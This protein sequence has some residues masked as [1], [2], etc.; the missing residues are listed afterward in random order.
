M[1]ITSGLPTMNVLQNFFSP[2]RQ[3][4]SIVFSRDVSLCRD[5][6][7]LRIVLADPSV[8]AGAPRPPSREQIKKQK[9]AQELALMQKQLAELLD[10]GSATRHTM[11]HLVFVEQALE[12]KGLR[13]LHKLPLE[14]LERA[15]DQF[16]GLVTNWSPAGLA[17]LRSKMAVAIIDREHMDPDAEAD[18]Y[19]TSAVVESAPQPTARPQVDAGS[20]TTEITDA[21]ALAAA[22]AAL[23]VVGV[24]SGDVQT[25]V[26]LGSPSA[27]A[28]TREQGRS[29]P[30][31]AE[32][33]A[34]TLQFRLRELQQ[35]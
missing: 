10:L 33:E 4:W 32:S 31:A 27:R 28:V 34:G 1:F 3:L 11:R 15:L 12:K 21:D 17:S 25:Q 2:V 5:E 14:V 7:S 24:S 20:D 30:A 8:P 16:E 29:G 26:E 18:A 13:A 9:E 19:N 6:G 23:G 22:Y 35:H